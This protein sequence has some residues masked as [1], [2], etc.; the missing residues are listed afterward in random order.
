VEEG[1]LSGRRM[2]RE[3]RKKKQ[4]RLRHEVWHWSKKRLKASLPD[5]A[6]RREPWG[7]KHRGPG[8]SKKKR[9]GPPSI[10]Q[11]KRPGTVTPG[12]RDR[13]SGQARGHVKVPGKGSGHAGKKSRLRCYH[14]SQKQTGEKKKEGKEGTGHRGGPG[15]SH[16]K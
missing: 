3:R 16:R 2:P 9:D 13:T 8:S 14:L 11:K 5:T 10:K 12:E 15:G 6:S 1:R 7:T 4:E